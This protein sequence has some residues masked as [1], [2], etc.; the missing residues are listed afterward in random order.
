[1]PNIV[2]SNASENDLIEIGTYISQ[3]SPTAA[4]RL[5]DHIE[6]TLMLLASYPQIGVSRPNLTKSGRSFTVDRYVIYYRPNS[7]GI[8]VI[9]I[10]HS[11]RDLRNLR[12]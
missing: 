1:M 8:V 12:V 2:R 7:E 5:L 6:A 10:L 9:R 4:N 3:D 11:A